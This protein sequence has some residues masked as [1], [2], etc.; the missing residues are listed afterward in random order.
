MAAA[1]SAEWLGKRRNTVHSIGSLMRRNMV[2]SEESAVFIHFKCLNHVFSFFFL[3]KQ[4]FP[5]AQH[6]STTSTGIFLRTRHLRSACWSESNAGNVLTMHVYL[7]QPHIKKNQN[8]P[9]K[10][11]SSGV[12]FLLKPLTAKWNHSGKGKWGLQMTRE[13]G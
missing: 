12:I 1:G 9:F 2:V 13:K 3:W 6:F 5:L 7:T 8:Y 10:L 11:A 4:H